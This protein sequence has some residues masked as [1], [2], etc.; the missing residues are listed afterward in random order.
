MASFDG[1]MVVMGG[2][3][4]QI[5]C[6]G[7]PGGGREA[8]IPIKDLFATDWDQYDEGP[9]GWLRHTAGVLMDFIIFGENARYRGRFDQLVAGVIEGKPGPT[10]FAAVFPEVLP[11]DSWNTKI[12]AHDRELQYLAG[13]PVRGL[14]PLGFEIPPEKRADP[15]QREVLPAPPDQ[16]AALLDAIKKLPRR[17]DGYPAW[18]PSEVIARVR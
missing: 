16:I 4:R 17:D 2:K 6:F 14:C 12:S 15:D 3:G 7:R 8:L 1:A 9:R 10:L 5:A 18:Y 11:L 13:T